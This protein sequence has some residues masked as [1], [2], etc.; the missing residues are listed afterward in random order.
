MKRQTDVSALALASRELL[1][2]GDPVG[3]ERVLA[4]VFSQLGADASVLHL[5][6]LIKKAQN[7]MEE[8]E[9]HFRSAVAYSLDDGGY[10]NDLPKPSRFSAPRWRSC[11]KQ[12]KCASTWCAATSPPATS[13]RRREKR[14]PT[15]NARRARKPGR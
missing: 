2:R 12:R 15:S 3:A 5:M 13:P 14:K 8:A 10:Y 6:G 7:K 9:R 11:R 4:P 1:N